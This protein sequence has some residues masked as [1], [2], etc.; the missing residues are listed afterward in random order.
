MDEDSVDSAYAPTFRFKHSTGNF[1]TRA[2]RMTAPRRPLPPGAPE[3]MLECL[4]DSLEVE[5]HGDAA[6]TT[7]RIHVRRAGGEVRWRNYRSGTSASSR[8]LPPARTGGSSSST[9]Q[10][11]TAKGRRPRSSGPER[12]VKA[13]T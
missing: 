2:T 6:L 1:G 3:R 12:H 9:T 7:G 13:A 11:T 8:A 5:V 4:V 10:R